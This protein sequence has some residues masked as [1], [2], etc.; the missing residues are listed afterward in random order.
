MIS[1]TFCKAG[2]SISQLS[3]MIA[4]AWP[5]FAG[6]AE[7]FKLTLA[8]FSI[9]M[10]NLKSAWA[11]K[12]PRSCTSHPNTV[13]LSTTRCSEGRGLF[14]FF[15]DHFVEE[16]YEIFAIKGKKVHIEYSEE[17]RRYTTYQYC[18]SYADNDWMW[19]IEL[20][21]AFGK[22]EVI[23]CDYSNLLNGLVNGV[24][25]FGGLGAH[26]QIKAKMYICA[27]V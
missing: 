7:T 24:K 11:F 16:S 20:R 4:G 1:K 10:I 21:G 6:N 15:Q 19:L 25:F 14:S 9:Y 2:D 12:K 3:H 22:E 27:N 8:P 17:R 5:L 26:C 13:I 23:E 18:T